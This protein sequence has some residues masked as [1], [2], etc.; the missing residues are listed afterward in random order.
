MSI[1]SGPIAST[2]RLQ[3][4]VAMSTSEA[5]FNALADTVQNTAWVG[6]VLADLGQPQKEPTLVNQDNLGAIQWTEEVQGMRNVK[7]FGIKFH[8][9]REMVS[10]IKVV[11]RYATSQDNRA[12]CFTKI[13]QPFIVHRCHIGVVRSLQSSTAEEAC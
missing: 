2:S 1:N 5:E 13:G 3:T 10:N 4:A 9:V 6:A 11:I 7:Q 12:D 8:Y